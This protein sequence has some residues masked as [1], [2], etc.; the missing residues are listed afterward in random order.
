MEPQ[1]DTTIETKKPLL[2]VPAAIL[3]G[4]VVLALAVILVVPKASTPPTDTPKNE[5]P[6]TPTSIDT[7]SAKLR[8]SDHVKGDAGTAEVVLITYSD[9]DCPY[10]AKFHPTVQSVLTEYKGRVAWV[11]RQFPLE[12]HPNAYTESIAMECAAKLGGN[13]AFFTYLDTVV[14]VT[15]NADPKSNEALTTFAKNEGI[16]GTQFKTCL[17]DNSVTTKIDTDIAEA[18]KIGARGT[19]F[20]IAVNQKT[21]K[22][23][24]IPGAYPLEDVKE[25][26]NSIL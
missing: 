3:T 9:S 4:F 26:I 21:G 14:N 17:A 13:T 18:N 1:H 5:A 10:C 11:Y 15:L 20:S 24:V 8:S 22:Q 2:T 6:T 12:M 23:V 7:E 25:M 16:D 19:P